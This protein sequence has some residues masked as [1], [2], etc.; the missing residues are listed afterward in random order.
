[1]AN[2][3]IAMGYQ[4]LQLG[5]P[6]DAYAKV[7]GI[8]NAQ[9]QNALAQY[10]L[11]SAQRSDADQN[12]LRQFIPNVNES[13]RNQLLGYGASGKAA[14][15]ALMKG[16][17]DQR[18]GAKAQVELVDAKLKQSRSFLDTVKT[19]EEY[20]AWH[21][22][23]HAD[24]VLGPVLAARGITAEQSMGRIQQA[25]QTPGGFDTLVN[26]SKLGTEKFM[27]MNKPHFVNQANGATNQVLSM[28]GMGGPA[29]V[30]PGSVA[31][32]ASTPH[33]IA[34]EKAARDRLTQE[35]APGGTLSPETVDFLAETYRQTGSLPSLG[36]GKV[37]AETR[38]KVLGRAAELAMGGGKTAA[39][40]AGDVRGAK[41]DTAGATA[42]VKDFSSGMSARR[43]AANNTA[44]NHLATM[45]QL[46]SDLNNNDIRIVNAAG[47]AFAKATGAT[48]PT[49]F[50]AAR[51]L[52]ASEVIKAV[53]NNG[54]GVTERKEAEEQFARAN[55]PEQ[56]KGVIKTYKEL[57]AGQLDSLGL[58][59]E[60]GTGRKDFDK[61]LTPETRKTFEAV[62]GKTARSP[63]DQQA[64][65]WATANPTDPRAAQIKSKLGVK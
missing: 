45:E 27:E 7:M 35:T 6:L 30:V 51:Q 55:S 50:D 25:L 46:A 12:A 31:T 24:P 40:A 32:V 9:N 1:M 59:Y 2:T 5:N 29:T 47:N 39:D 15:E 23:N 19:P 38:N 18:E 56:L 33:Q 60:T 26:Q 41:A 28:P 34:M 64:L 63:V 14:Y 62:R 58:Q 57:L 65:D 17:K 42:T 22:A 16:D 44:I 11:S 48:A 37:A 52:V 10:Q 53:V 4:G 3:N 43:V 61:K 36:M 8:Q 13:N 20:I 49:S 21:Q 54:G